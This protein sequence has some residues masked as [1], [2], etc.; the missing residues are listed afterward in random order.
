MRPR[1]FDTIYDVPSSL[2][3]AGV[4][5]G[6]VSWSRTNFADFDNFRSKT[7]AAFPNPTEVVPTAYGGIDPGPAYTAPPS[8]S[9][10]IGGQAEATLD[11]LRAGSVAPG[12]N[13]LLVVSSPRGANDGIGADAQYLVNTSPVPAQVMT[14]SFGAC[15]SAAGSGGVAFWDNLFQTAAAE[16]ISVFVSSGDSGAAGC[17]TAFTAPPAMPKANSPNYICSSSYA[18]C[19]GGTQFA[20]TAS[21]STYWS[22]T[23]GAGYLSALG[24]IPEGAW[25]ESTTTSVAA[26]G[27]GVST[28]IATPS[29]QTGTGVPSARPAATRP[30]SPFPPPATM[31][32][33]PAWPPSPAA[34]ASPR[35]AASASSPS[36]EPRPP[37]P[38][39]PASPRCSIRNSAL[40]KATSIPQIYP[41]AASAPSAFHDATV[42]SSGV[43]GCSVN[44]ASICNNSVP[45]GTGT[46]PRPAFSWPPAT[47]KPPASAPSTCRPSSTT[48]PP[49]PQGSR[50]R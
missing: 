24:Y 28:V 12:A 47:T 17:D 16:G 39:W 36:P 19:V 35:M 37:R 33:S 13:L 22:S 34:V 6:I 5:I 7:G 29:W 32:I 44:T 25:N 46:A 50:P 8:G 2:T 45:G 48:S 4:T 30:T 38:A 3:G 11:V 20:D 27:G 42:A 40:R 18:T 15:E 21:P 26:T 14:I 41:L 23:N 10:S 31:A 43:S 9:I 1:D 49:R